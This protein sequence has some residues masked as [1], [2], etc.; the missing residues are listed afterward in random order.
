MIPFVLAA[1]GASFIGWLLTPASY[2]HDLPGLGL[3]LV[4]GFL[5][6]RWVYRVFKKKDK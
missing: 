6:G 1:M 5:I 4:V 3:S 2:G